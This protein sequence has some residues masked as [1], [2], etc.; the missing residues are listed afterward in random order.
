MLY[1]ILFHIIYE[2]DNFVVRKAIADDAYWIA[3]VNAHTRYTTYRWLMPQ[4]LLETRIN[5]IEKR[6]TK[7]RDGIINWVN[8]LVVENLERKDIVWMSI[9]WNSRNDK[10]PDSWEIYAIYILKDYQK[11]W[12]GK[13]L[14]FAGIE[15]L[16]EKWYNDMII[17]VLDWNP[18][19]NFY[20][21]YGGAVIWKWTFQAGENL[22]KEK[23]LFFKNIAD[24]LKM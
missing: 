17:N 5:T 19:I 8:Y 6:A 16:V 23:I 14:F 18:T 4:E 15:C 13:K 21:K 20:E 7:V 24:I 3:Y 10:Y 11:L 1:M 12:L 22:L 2:M 9:Y